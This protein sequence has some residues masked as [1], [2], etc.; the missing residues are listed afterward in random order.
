MDINDNAYFEELAITQEAIKKMFD[1]SA[2]EA[3]NLAL[4]YIHT[5]TISECLNTIAEGIG[6]IIE[7][8]NIELQNYETHSTS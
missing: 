6:E 5:R 7:L 4:K 3:A 2:Y 8:Q 1:L